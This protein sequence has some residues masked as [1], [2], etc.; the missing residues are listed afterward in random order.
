MGD[1]GG[2]F[3][4]EEASLVEEGADLRGDAGALFH[5]GFERGVGFE[6]EPVGLGHTVDFY[7][8]LGYVAKSHADHPIQCRMRRSSAMQKRTTA[9]LAKALR[10]A[11]VR[12]HFFDQNNPDPQKFVIGNHEVSVAG[13][14]WSPEADAINVTF[15][16]PVNRDSSPFAGID[17]DPGF[18]EGVVRQ[19]ER[20]E[21]RITLVRMPTVPAFLRTMFKVEAEPH[22][23]EAGFTI[24][25]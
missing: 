10:G 12:I 1:D 5:A 23:E 3:R 20:G 8:I 22:T 14:V 21:L 15:G 2:G 18:T 17:R 19:D 25:S 13:L 7:S 11:W 16:S 6:A 4:L 24:I 9:E